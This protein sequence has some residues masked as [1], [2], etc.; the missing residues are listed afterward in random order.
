M[1][2]LY[3]LLVG[4]VAGFLADKVV[5]NTFGLLGDLIVGVIGSFLGGWIFNQLNLN[6]GGLLGQIFVAFVGAVILLLLINLFR[7]KK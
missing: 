3:L 6:W 2:I 7:G 1:N 5:K 4:L